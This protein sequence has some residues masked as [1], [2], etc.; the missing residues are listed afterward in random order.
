MK[1]LLVPAIS[2]LVIFFVACNNES[3]EKKS[4]T[5]PK[6]AADSLMHDVMDGHNVAMAKMGKMSTTEKEMQHIIDSIA[7]LPA[8]IKNALAP[9]KIQLDTALRNLQSAQ[10]SMEKWMDEFNMDSAI[11]NMEERIKYLTDEKQK[12]ITVKEN[13]LLG[14][15]KA[16]SLIKEKTKL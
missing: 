4:E 8:K 13:I 14:L 1:K 7:K 5:T 16:D 9:Y 2:L 10:A 3:N 11:N 15:A 6:T 12:V